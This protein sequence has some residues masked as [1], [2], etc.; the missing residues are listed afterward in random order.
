MLTSI[1]GI[2]PDD[3]EDWLGDLV[4][5]VASVGVSFV[6]DQTKKFSRH[7][8]FDKFT[9]EYIQDESSF[10]NR[11]KMMNVHFIFGGHYNNFSSIYKRKMCHFVFQNTTLILIFQHTQSDE[12]VQKNVVFRLVWVC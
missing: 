9:D 4:V 12:F 1:T 3:M 7:I 8:D 2:D 10:I 5:M 6:D 11:S